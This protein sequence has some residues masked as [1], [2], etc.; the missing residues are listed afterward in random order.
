[1]RY[2][3]FVVDG[4]KVVGAAFAWLYRKGVKPQVEAISAVVSYI[5]NKGLKPAFSKMK[6]A[7]G[8]VADAFESARKSIKASWKQVSEHVKGPVNFVID[9][10]YTK[11]IKKLFDGVSKYVG[12]E[13]LPKAPKLLEAGGTVGNGWSIAKPMKTNRPTAIVGEGNP[14]YPEYVIPT[15]PKYRA[16]AMSLHQA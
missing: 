10:V 12:M 16:R 4:I 15:D 3:G 5:Y 1:K 14:R 8:L 9:F 7:V 11:G 6:T 13:P 2:F